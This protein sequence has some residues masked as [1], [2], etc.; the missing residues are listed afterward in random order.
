[1]T[2]PH[3]YAE[4]AAVLDKFRDRIDDE[5]TLEAMHNGTLEWQA[6]VAERFTKKFADTMNYRMNN[7]AERFRNDISRSHAQESAIVQALLSLRKE[8]RIMLSAVT[9]PA[10]PEEY[11]VRYRQLIFDRADEMQSNL[12]NSAK[13]DRTGRL[14]SIIRNNRVNIL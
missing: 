9:L 8:L 4:W 11:R 7:A 13:S 1:M 5:E 2:A 10:I 12:E 3:T 14:L 6:G